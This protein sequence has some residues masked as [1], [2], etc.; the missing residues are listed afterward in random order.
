MQAVDEAME[1]MIGEVRTQETETPDARNPAHF[2]RLFEENN[3]I[4]GLYWSEYVEERLPSL[5]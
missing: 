4:G 1:D 3:A 2:R 5:V